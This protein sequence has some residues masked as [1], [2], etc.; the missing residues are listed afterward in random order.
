M[1]RL[2]SFMFKLLEN[3]RR[4]RYRFCGEI[5]GKPKALKTSTFHYLRVFN[6][7]KQRVSVFVFDIEIGIMISGD[8]A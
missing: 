4:Q 8:Q 3:Q 1:D 6:N 2:D 5:G 7:A